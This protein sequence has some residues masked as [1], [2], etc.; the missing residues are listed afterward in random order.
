MIPMIAIVAIRTKPRPSRR[1]W[2][3]LPLFLMWLLL[4]PLILILL[5][6]VFITCWVIGVDPL[7]ALSASWELLCG[8]RNSHI[9]V[10]HRQA[11]LLIRFH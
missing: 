2:I 3:P 8:V 6:F 11:S 1:F 10:D 7:R 5:P 9:E 4:L